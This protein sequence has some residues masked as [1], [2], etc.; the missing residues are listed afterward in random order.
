M[1]TETPVNASAPRPTPGRNPG[2]VT[3]RGGLGIVI[4]AAVAS[5][6]LALLF[7]AMQLGEIA[8]EFWAEVPVATPLELTPQVSGSAGEAYAAYSTVVIRSDEPLVGA[9][10]MAGLAVGLR[11][12]LFIAACAVVVLLAVRLWRRMRFSTLATGSVAGFGLASVVVAFAAPWLQLTSI[13]RGVTELG[14]PLAG[15]DPSLA[16]IPRDAR[17]WVVPPEFTLQDTDWL[18]LAFGVILLLAAVLLRG[19]QRLQRD[20]EGL[21]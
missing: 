8:E 7:L 19:A 12:A 6:L 3:L 20:T 17:E 13:V 18:L 15:D 2:A 16:G 1:R 21:I 14:Y 10:G 9:R 4:A 5:G 11:F